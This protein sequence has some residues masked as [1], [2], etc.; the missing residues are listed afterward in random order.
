MRLVA[1]TDRAEQIT[2]VLADADHGRIVGGAT[3]AQYGQRLCVV[4]Q[5]ILVGIDAA[6]PSRPRHRGNARRAPDLRLGEVVTQSIEVFQP[7]RAW[8]RADSR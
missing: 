7:R 2:H 5:R 1:A 3:V 8:C 4:A 6:R